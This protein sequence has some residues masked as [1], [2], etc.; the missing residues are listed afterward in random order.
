[1]RINWRGARQPDGLTCRQGEVQILSCRIVNDCCLKL[2]LNG[3]RVNYPPMTLIDIIGHLIVLVLILRWDGILDVR[4]WGWWIRVQ[5]RCPDISLARMYERHGWR[6]HGYHRWWPGF[7]HLASGFRL[8]L[9]L[10]HLLL[11]FIFLPDSLHY[12]SNQRLLILTLILIESY[13]YPLN[14]DL[15]RQPLDG[16]FFSFH[17]VLVLLLFD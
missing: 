15:V 14:P 6:C 4:H 11:L 16:E 2:I 9:W 12:F 8:W 10:A 13:Y 17:L 5:R 1:M 7:L 3:W